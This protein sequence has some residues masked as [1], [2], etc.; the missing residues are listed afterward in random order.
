MI[1]WRVVRVS[2]FGR[3]HARPYA[4]LSAAEEHEVSAD[5]GRV[6]VGV[7]GVGPAHRLGPLA[8]EDGTEDELAHR[9]R[10]D[11]RPDE[12]RGS[13][14]HDL[15][16]AAGVRVE[17]LLRHR[18]ARR[19]LLVLGPRRRGLGHRC[20][21]G[22]AVRV[23]VLERDETGT[24]RA[25]GGDNRVLQRRELLRPPVV[26]GCVQAEV[27]GARVT[28]DVLGEHGVG[29]VAA[30]DLGAGKLA[31]AASVD[32]HDVVAEL[33]EVGDHVTADLAGAENHVPVHDA[34]RRGA[35]G[36]EHAAGPR[37]RR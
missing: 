11:A 4:S 37:W 17:E 31:A 29:D 23:E 19:A 3:C 12:V 13:P 34:L 1:T 14:D 18:R 35:G 22:V 25:R 33:D 16:V 2:G 30:D 5:I 32:G 15:E 6:A 36:E 20:S 9:R 21:A 7:R 26:V 27:D 8:R 28:G 24:V 10:G